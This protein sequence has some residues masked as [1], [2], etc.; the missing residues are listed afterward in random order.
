MY[1]VLFAVY[2]AFFTLQKVGNAA[3]DCAGGAAVALR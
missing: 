1:T 3:T 2:F